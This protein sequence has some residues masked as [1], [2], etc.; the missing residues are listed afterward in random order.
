MDTNFEEIC[1]FE[2]DIIVRDFLRFNGWKQ[3]DDGAIIRKAFDRNFIM[4]IYP[5]ILSNLKMTQIWYACRITLNNDKLLIDTF[6]K[7][8][9]E[10]FKELSYKPFQDDDAYYGNFKKRIRKDGIQN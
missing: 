3:L 1:K 4:V 2:V 9:K 10:I 8:F 6:V 7:Y 5:E